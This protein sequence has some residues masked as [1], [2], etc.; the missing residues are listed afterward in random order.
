MSAFITRLRVTTC[1]LRRSAAEVPGQVLSSTASV[2]R[3]P[4]SSC[5]RPLQSPSSVRAAICCARHPS[6][7][8]SASRVSSCAPPLW[9]SA[10]SILGRCGRR[11]LR[12]SVASVVSRFGRRSLWFWHRVV[13]AVVHVRCGACMLLC[14]PLCCCACMLSC[15][16]AVVHMCCCACMLLHAV[17]HA[18]CCA[19]MQLRLHA[20][21]HTCGCACMLLCMHV[22]C[23]ACMLLCMHVC[24][25]ACMLL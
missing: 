11:S 2:L 25:C 17:A 15:M 1:P 14:L 12:S 7:C 24:C 21:V 23:C 13:N 18:C 9:S 10:A 22:C 5:P 4:A 16:H 20:A 6:D 8:S 3:H 19:C